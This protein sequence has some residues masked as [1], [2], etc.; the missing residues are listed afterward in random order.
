MVSI[1]ISRVV[2]L[3]MP[4]LVTMGEGVVLDMSRFI[5]VDEGLIKVLKML[6]VG[7]VL[8]VGLGYGSA[9]R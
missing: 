5:M 2:M 3:R 8:L 9:L 6:V 4:S 1:V 7:L